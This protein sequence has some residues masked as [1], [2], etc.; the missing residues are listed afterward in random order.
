MPVEFDVP[1]LPDFDALCA[2]DVTIA[3]V[4]DHLWG[5]FHADS[6]VCSTFHGSE[7]MQKNAVDI[8]FFGDDSLKST[9]SHGM[10]VFN[11]GS[12]HLYT[13]DNERDVVDLTAALGANV[14]RMD[15]NQRATFDTTLDLTQS[16]S[17]SG[18]DDD[19][20]S[21]AGSPPADSLEHPEQIVIGD[22]PTLVTDLMNA[23]TTA[24]HSPNTP[25]RRRR[26][27]SLVDEQFDVLLRE[28][29][30]KLAQGE[31]AQQ[32]ISTSPVPVT[33]TKSKPVTPAPEV[34]NMVGTKVFPSTAFPPQT[35]PRTSSGIIPSSPASHTASPSPT[36]SLI[37]SSPQPTRTLSP[38]RAKGASTDPRHASIRKHV[39]MTCKSRF[40]CKSKLDRHMLTH[41]GAK[42]FGCF[43]GK[44]FNQKSALKN[45][46]RR[47]LKKRDIPM[48]Q[49][50]GT[51]LNGFTYEHLV[52]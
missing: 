11:T 10:G 6:D 21:S 44:R 16:P 31:P 30:G 4:S 42:P 36:L 45:H 2:N 12:T 47:H 35:P 33:P 25:R 50:G 3:D 1:E 32:L 48:E 18:I 24:V 29:R 41:T 27:S 34:D 37:P 28:A 5:S 52:A 39:C 19:T 7:P 51:G 26:A 17:D 22:T 14:T 15:Y 13:W 8:A 38:G 9:K 43:C 23:H 40:L 49:L 20:S 46:T